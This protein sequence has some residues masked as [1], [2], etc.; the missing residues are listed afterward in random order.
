MTKC[1]GSSNQS[2]NRFHCSI[3]QLFEKF[4]RWPIITR[5]FEPISLFDYSI[6]RLF[7]KFV[8]WPII[9]RIFEP[10]FEPIFEL[11]LEPIFESILLFDYLIIWKIREMANHYK[12][13]RTDLGTD[14][15]TNLG[16]D[17]RTDF[18][19]RLYDLRNL[20]DGQSLQESLNRFHCSIMRLFEKFMRWPI[21]TRIFEPISL[22]DY[23]IWEICEMTNHYKN[24]NRSSNRS[25]NRSSNRSWNQ[26]LNRFHCSIIWLF[27][28]FVRW[29]IITR[30][31][32]LIFEP[33]FEP[34]FESIS[35]FNYSI[36]RLFEKFVR[37]PII[38]RI[39]IILV[40]CIFNLRMALKKMLIESISTKNIWL[41]VSIWNSTLFD[42]YSI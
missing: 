26:F 33:I 12:N 41:T 25:L 17:F 38:R 24:L 4:V 28:K 31:F 27:E 3:I 37:W 13:L 14:F 2:S 20:W 21:I 11:I 6:I 30:I 35:L 32:E 19:V 18:T 9:T 15:R 42:V 5:I 22:F 8:R 23:T 1:D 36:I 39:Y 10:I 40:R 34:I 16:T 7:E 29:P